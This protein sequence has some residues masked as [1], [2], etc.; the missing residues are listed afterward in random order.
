MWGGRGG[1]K[2]HSVA[3]ALLAMAA[4]KKMRILCA[5]EVQKSMRDSV[6]RLLKDQIER[7]G[8]GGF[9]LVLDNEIRGQNGSLFVFAGLQSHTVDSIKSFEGVDIVWVEEAHSVSKKS[10]DVLIPTIRKDGSEIWRDNPWL[11][12]E[13]P[14]T[15]KNGC[16]APA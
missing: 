3:A 5:R 10:W 8:L 14:G 2:S 1:G 16:N 12:D 11:A 7:L 6:H 13:Q 4:S 15:G 9:Y